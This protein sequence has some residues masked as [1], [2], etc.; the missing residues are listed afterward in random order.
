[1]KR[2]VAFLILTIF[3]LVLIAS[4]PF[5]VH[6]AS[7]QNSGYSIQQVDHQMEV[8]YSGQIIIR[9]KIHITGQVTD[10]FLIGFPQK[11][12]AYV[13]KGVAYDENGILPMS[14]NVPFEGHSDLYG[15]SISFP[16]TPPQVFTVVFILSNDIVHQNNTLNAAAVEFP[17]YPSLA[18]EAAKCNVTLVLPDF[19]SNPTITKDGETMSETSFIINNLAAFT[20]APAAVTFTMPIGILQLFSVTNLNRVIT[21]SPAGDVAA[22]DSYRIVNN[23]NDT[24]VALGVDVP[25]DAENIIGKDEHGRDLT[26]EIVGSGSTFNLVNVTFRSYL[27]KN[28]AAMLTV[29]Y[30]LPRAV[31]EQINTFRL[32][33]EPFPYF[34]YYVTEASVT[35]IPPEGAN[36]LTYDQTASLHK[37]GLQE[38]L[39]YNKAGVSHVDLEVASET[40]Q[41]TYS[42]NPLW[43]SFRPT[44]WVWLLA[45]VG[46]IVVAFW[47]RPKTS[48]PPKNA[49]PKPSISLSSDNIRTFIEA[50]EEKTKITSKLSLLNERAQK[51]KISRRRY[52]VQKRRLT[53]RSA[54]LSKEIAELKEILRGEGSNC[55][56]L[57]RQL[58]T[59]E[60]ELNQAETNIN[61]IENRHRKGAISA[62]EY[63][64]TLAEHQQR[65]EKAEATINGILLRL[66]EETR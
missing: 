20:D 24:L 16:Q 5:A 39:T 12:G 57:V 19:A 21:I 17:L 31:S 42:Y 44:L 45:A 47:K 60:T 53:E 28:Q 27:T 36:F 23:G 33:L 34:D 48:T 41:T 11:Y 13:L 32:N 56:S 59:A 30:T 62:E 35:V 58:N 10:G 1:V 37:D 14:L 6:T 9:D 18:K 40:V 26:V 15:A 38:T 52:K 4:F 64:K 46:C 3:S 61:S 2:L 49:A 29:E 54:A 65:K 8:M 51:G 66:R 22:S 63:K 55:A 50:Y 7:A 25:L 43:L